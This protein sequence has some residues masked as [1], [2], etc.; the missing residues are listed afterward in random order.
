MHVA[1]DSN[2]QQRFRTVTARQMS[3]FVLRAA[4]KYE[5]RRCQMW[6]KAVALLRY[7]RSPL[8][9]P[10]KTSLMIG[11]RRS[12]PPSWLRRT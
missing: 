3:G 6:A 1:S 12:Y 7:H 11:Q 4:A 5:M 2:L 10:P 8:I 9:V